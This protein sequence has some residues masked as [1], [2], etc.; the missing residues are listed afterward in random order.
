MQ[1]MTVPS[2]YKCRGQ[3]KYNIMKKYI[4]H[5]DF[6]SNNSDLFLTPN[7]LPFEVKNI[8]DSWEDDTYEECIR[9]VGELEPYGYTFDYD[10]NAVA[11]NLRKINSP[12]TA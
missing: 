5:D 1:P 2:P 9:I 6:D 3:N 10:L 8:L 4:R 11:S 12:K 7:K